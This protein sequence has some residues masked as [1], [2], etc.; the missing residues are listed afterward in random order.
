MLL[1]CQHL[2]LVQLLLKVGAKGCQTLLDVC[3]VACQLVERSEK[4]RRHLGP[5]LCELLFDL[6]QLRRAV[7]HPALAD[8]QLLVHLPLHCCYALLCPQRLISVVSQLLHETFLVSGILLLQFAKPGLVSLYLIPL[9]H[10]SLVQYIVLFLEREGLL[11][12]LEHD[13]DEGFLQLKKSWSD[14]RV[15]INCEKIFRPRRRSVP[16]KRRCKMY[17]V[18]IFGRGRYEFE[19]VRQVVKDDQSCFDSL[20]CSDHGVVCGFV[21]VF[22]MRALLS[23]TLRRRSK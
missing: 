10:N 6:T 5:K 9:E 11:L 19:R 1:R 7:C 13:F 3:L 22:S 20:S 18:R 2:Y 12:S 4:V 16:G 8:A 23:N 14:H 21:H 17:S 15:H